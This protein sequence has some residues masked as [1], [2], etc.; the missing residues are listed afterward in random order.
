MGLTN[1]EGQARLH[2][3]LAHRE[4]ALRDTRIRNMH[5]VE[6]LLRAQQMRVDEFSRHECE[7]KSRYS[8]AGRF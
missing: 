2:E 7:A 4:K 3:E 6:E 1:L 5:E 8:F